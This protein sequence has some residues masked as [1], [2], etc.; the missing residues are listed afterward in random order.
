[1]LAKFSLVDVCDI[2]GFLRLESECKREI[3]Q[4][5]DCGGRYFASVHDMGVYQ[6]KLLLVVESVC[7]DSNCFDHCLDR[8]QKNE[9]KLMGN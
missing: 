6:P 4:I 3:A 2:S 7:F 1:M 9:N 5:L 8:G